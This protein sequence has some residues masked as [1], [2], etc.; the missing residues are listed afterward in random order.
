MDFFSVPPTVTTMANGQWVE[1]FPIS[2]LEDH[3]PV[4]FDIKGNGEDYIDLAQTYLYVKVKIIQGNGANLEADAKVGPINNFLHSMFSEIDMSLN[5][6]LVTSSTGLYPYRA[7]FEN[8]MYSKTSKDTQL[9]S[10]VLWSKDAA[11]K[12]NEHDSTKDDDVGNAGYN[13]RAKIV[14]ES[15]TFEMYDTLHLDMFVQE[16]YLLNGIDMRLRFNRTKPTF[17]LMGESADNKIQI[18]QAIL[19][20]RK[21]RPHPSIANSIAKQ[22]TQTTA[23]YPIR[24]VEI[25]TFTIPT[26]TRSLIQDNL[27]QGQ[28]PKRVILGIVPNAALNGN[29]RYNPFNFNNFKVCKVDVIP[30]G[31]PITTRPFEPDFRSSRAW[32]RD[33][34]SVYQCLGKLRSDYSFDITLDEYPHGYCLWGYDFTPDQGADSDVF[35]PIQQGNVRVE[36]QFR[37][38]PTAAL[39]VVVYAEFDNCIEISHTREVL[40]DF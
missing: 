35:H 36:L 23:K 16:K 10:R 28:L 14:S 40:L 34:L 2:S 39:N 31:Q 3:S 30:E 27:F 37:E 26:G 20:V 18:L 12:F 13:H 6:K 19:F 32:L 8:L 1:H 7:Y 33:Y 11:S 9:E 17:C 38:A 24:R 15:K 21:V 29:E 25:K 4:E 5:G 22:L